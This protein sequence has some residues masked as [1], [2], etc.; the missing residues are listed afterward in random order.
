VEC[1]RPSLNCAGPESRTQLKAVTTMTKVVRRILPTV[2]NVGLSAVHSITGHN[3]Q[4]GLLNLRK[5]AHKMTESIYATVLYQL[6]K[7]M[8]TTVTTCQIL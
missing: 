8:L 1:R 5:T 6:P 2:S 7:I 3:P 4:L